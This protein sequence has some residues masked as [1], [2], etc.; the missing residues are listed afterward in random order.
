MKFLLPLLLLAGC[1]TPTLPARVDT[2]YVASKPDTVHT[3]TRDTLITTHVDTVVEI[4][5]DTLVQVRLDTVIEVR[6]RLDTVFKTVMDTIVLP[7]KVVH[8]TAW[9]YTQT[10]PTNPLAGGDP[11]VGTIVLM[12]YEGFAIVFWHGHF[13]GVL[14]AQGSYDDLRWFAWMVP[15]PG[16]ILMVR[17]ND[18]GYA[19][20]EEA[21]RALTPIVIDLR[22]SLST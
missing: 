7:A 18:A 16:S 6:I 13:V 5:I 8:D 20:I 14:R 19:T 12:V 9:I 15:P 4:R 11:K 10:N 3:H 2:V 17:T 21:A 22:P 1:Q